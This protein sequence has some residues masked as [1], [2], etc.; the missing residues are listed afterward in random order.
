M[1]SDFSYGNSSAHVPLP[2][3]HHVGQMGGNWSLQDPG[4]QLQQKA[5]MPLW[6]VWQLFWALERSRMFILGCPNLIVSTDRLPLVGILNDRALEGIQNPRLLKF[7]ERTLRLTF[8]I[9]HSKG[10]LN[11]GQDALSHFPYRAKE[12]PSSGLAL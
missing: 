9:Q 12:E 2:A 5:N 11:S 6:R 8:H 4:P 1:A 10:Q 7:K 3:L